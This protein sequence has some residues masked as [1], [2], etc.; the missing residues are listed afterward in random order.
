VCARRLGQGR[1][2]AALFYIYTYGNSPP[3]CLPRP[4]CAARCA[5]ATYYH[6]F[7][8]SIPSSRPAVTLSF[9]V[10][11]RICGGC[12][13]RQHARRLQAHAAAFGDGPLAASGGV[14]DG[15]AARGD[16]TG[17]VAASGEVT[18]G[19]AASGDLTGGGAVNADATYRYTR[20][21]SVMAL[22]HTGHTPTWQGLTLFNFSAKR[23]HCS[24]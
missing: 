17:G 18:G 4:R 22:W 13:G 24:K 9:F 23:K 3:P 5:R 14:T 10:S 7:A 20:R 21:R 16:V 2:P 11:C 15:G 19:G 12:F 1:K 6:L 8:C